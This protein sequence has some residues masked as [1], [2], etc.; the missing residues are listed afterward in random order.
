L[1]INGI[2]L[3]SVCKKNVARFRVSVGQRRKNKR[4]FV[5]NAVGI[6]HRN[7]RGLDPVEDPNRSIISHT[8]QV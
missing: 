2:E 7:L 3:L 5:D 1:R 4:G 6:K 8:D